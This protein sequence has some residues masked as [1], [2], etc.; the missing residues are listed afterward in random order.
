VT[1]RMRVVMT[2]HARARLRKRYPQFASWTL[3][4]IE[5]GVTVGIDSHVV[6]ATLIDKRR[7]ISFRLGGHTVYGIGTQDT[8]T[9]P[10]CILTIL[11]VA[12]AHEY[13]EHSLRVRSSG[14]IDGGRGIKKTRRRE[15]RENRRSWRKGLDS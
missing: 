6:M 2:L 1:N 7:L 3:E 15:R 8:D 4:E 5:H 9:A 13:A 10:F 12:M 14:P 11:T